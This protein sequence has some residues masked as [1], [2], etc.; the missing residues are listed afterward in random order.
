MSG[1]STRALR[2]RVFPKGNPVRAHQFDPLPNAS[3]RPADG[4]PLR[5]AKTPARR[6]PSPATGRPKRREKVFGPGRGRPLDRNARARLLHLARA[7]MHRTEPGKHYGAVTAKA[8][9]ILEALL[10]RFHNAKDGRTFPS[11]QRIAEAAHC[12]PSTVGPA[13]KA[14]EAAGLLTWDNR[15]VRIRESCEDL[16]G[17][18][19]WRW[20]VI[21]TSNAYRFDLAASLAGLWA[22]ASKTELQSITQNSESIP[23]SETAQAP[24][25]AL[26][27]ALAASFE[28][29]RTL[30]QRKAEAK[31]A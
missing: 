28:H 26:S 5:W 14:L 7:L 4:R 3:Q 24:Q 2:W 25:K 1:A 29:L 21:R 13:I 15:L 17:P 27:E 16:L 23:L 9:A 19:G 6:S 22:K 20:R 31:P 10:W 18:G 30:I 11:Y 12:A 8:F